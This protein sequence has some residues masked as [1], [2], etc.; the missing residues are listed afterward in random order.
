VEPWTLFFSGF[1]FHFLAKR[2]ASATFSCHDV[3][4]HLRPKA[5]GPDDR[6]KLPKLSQNKHFIFISWLSQIFII[7]S[8][9]WLKQYDNVNAFLLWTEGKK[10]KSL[11]I[12]KKIIPV[13][14][15]IRRKWVKWEISW[16]VFAIYRHVEL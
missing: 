12:K 1:L 7:V 13:I 4:P 9:I 11:K 15:K 10:G 5:K 8:K 14:E 2:W 6:L 3:L 16:E